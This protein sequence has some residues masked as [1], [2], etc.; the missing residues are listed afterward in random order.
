[1]YEAENPSD[2]TKSLLGASYYNK[3]FQRLLT[4]LTVS[5]ATG[6][7]YEV[8]LRLR[9][10]GNDSMIAQNFGQYQHYYQTEARI[11]ERLA[12]TRARV[13][14]NIGSGDLGARIENFIHEQLQDKTIPDSQILTAIGEMRA[15]I[16]QTHPDTGLFNI[17]HKK[18][19]LLELEF[20]LQILYWQAIRAGKSNF[21]HDYH[22]IIDRLA[23]INFIDKVGGGIASLWA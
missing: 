22:L 6:E 17:K 21:E 8:D 9:P 11:W 5:T 13:I 20:T 12:L 19:G 18:G 15:R 7:L 10:W 1:M 3:F 2:G 23:E 4:A 14:S 16:T